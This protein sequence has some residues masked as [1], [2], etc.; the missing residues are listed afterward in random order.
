MFLYYV[1]KEMSFGLNR[2]YFETVKNVGRIRYAIRQIA[3]I[4]NKK[5]GFQS[6]LGLCIDLS[7]LEALFS[8]FYWQIGCYF[9]ILILL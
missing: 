7:S 9:F 4:Y 2:I 6:G 3:I 8:Y 5:Y 1:Y